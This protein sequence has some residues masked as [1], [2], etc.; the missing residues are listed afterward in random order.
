MLNASCLG[1][2]KITLSLYNRCA[3]DDDA[4]RA[5]LSSL[6]QRPILPSVKSRRFRRLEVRLQHRDV[7]VWTSG[8]LLPDLALIRLVFTWLVLRVRGVRSTREIFYN[9]TSLC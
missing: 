9:N 2:G 4:N 7:Q 1:P 6:E 5:C 8:S 3:V